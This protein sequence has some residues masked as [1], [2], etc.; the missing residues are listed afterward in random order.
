MSAL[1]N[2]LLHYARVTNADDVTETVDLNEIVELALL[3]LQ[4]AIEEAGA[5]VTA[6]QLRSS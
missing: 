4:V 6:E 3:N 5:S 2:D 1:I